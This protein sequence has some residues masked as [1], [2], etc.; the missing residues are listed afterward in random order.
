M[1]LHHDVILILVLDTLVPRIYGQDWIVIHTLELFTFEKIRYRGMVYSILLSV[2]L[3]DCT[4]NCVVFKSHFR[5]MILTTIT[6]TVITVIVKY[7]SL[8]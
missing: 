7:K 1:S 4:T 5:L 2:H 6:K 8:C 3:T